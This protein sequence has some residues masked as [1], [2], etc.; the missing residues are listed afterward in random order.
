M[1]GSCC[2]CVSCSARARTC[3]SG[4]QAARLLVKG[5]QSLSLLISLSELL[6][7]LPPVAAG[8]VKPCR[9]VRLRAIVYAYLTAVSRWQAVSRDV[10]C[11]HTCFKQAF[12]ARQ[13]CKISFEAASSVCLNTCWADSLKPCSV[14][15]RCTKLFVMLS[16][17]EPAPESSFRLHTYIYRTPH[18]DTFCCLAPFRKHSSSRKHFSSFAKHHRQH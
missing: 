17:I 4:M 15:R 5:S 10:Q 18:S 2:S 12:N 14:I 3:C 13:R 7:L 11:P 8:G 6:V 16:G 1:A 9:Q